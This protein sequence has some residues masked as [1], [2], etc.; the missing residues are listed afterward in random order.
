MLGAS[1][2]VRALFG[3]PCSHFVLSASWDSSLCMLR[4]SISF[5]FLIKRSFVH[6]CSKY[7]TLPCN[8][9]FLFLCGV[10]QF[11]HAQQII[12]YRHWSPLGIISRCIYAFISGRVFLSRGLALTTLICRLPCWHCLISANIHNRP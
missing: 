7:M 10:V 11:A 12:I 3:D 1:L 5:A 8:L 2:P 9:P 6:G 4:D